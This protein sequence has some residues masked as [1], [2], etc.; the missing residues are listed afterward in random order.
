MGTPCKRPGTVLAAPCKRLDDEIF[1]MT[2]YILTGAPG[3]G[4]TTI[5]LALRQRGYAVVEEAA[6]E[7]IA[8]A[9]AGG[10]DAPWE[11]EDFVERIALMQ[12]S[13]RLASG[14]GRQDVEFHDRSVVC[15]VALNQLFERTAP[16]ILTREVD[17]L[18]ADPSV[19]R[20][21]FFIDDLGFI[22]NTAARRISYEDA[23]AFGALH[24]AAYAAHGYHLVRIGAGPVEDRVAAILKLV[25]DT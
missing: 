11:L 7:V 22:E 17:A 20:T 1:P 21:V 14:A 6:T 4:K 24:E 15:T 8:Q 12:R 10:I 5:I 2:G 9:Q 18:K 23:V 13:R 19:S 3:A 25:D 16:A